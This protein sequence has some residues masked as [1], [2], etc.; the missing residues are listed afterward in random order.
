MCT[1]KCYQAIFRGLASIQHKRWEV[2]QC[3]K[4]AP[5]LYLDK[6]ELRDRFLIFL[7]SMRLGRVSWCLLILVIE[8]TVATEDISAGKGLWGCFAIPLCDPR[9]LFGCR[10][11]KPRCSQ[12]IFRLVGPVPA[13]KVILCAQVLS[14]GSAKNRPTPL[15]QSGLI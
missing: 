10:R 13:G 4:R 1:K 8:D 9:D 7:C 11:L 2:E 6:L 5:R 14:G 12:N 15:L 3:K